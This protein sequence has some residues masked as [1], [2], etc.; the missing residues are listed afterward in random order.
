M[1]AALGRRARRELDM[2]MWATTGMLVDRGHGPAKRTRLVHCPRPRLLLGGSGK[3]HPRPGPQLGTHLTP[4]GS[5]MGGQPRTDDQRAPL[6][7]PRQRPDQRLHPAAQRK[8]SPRAHWRLRY[9]R[10]SRGDTR[11]ADNRTSGRAAG[12][13]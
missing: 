9:R 11:I 10:A 4:S 3:E 12:E 6:H 5:G 13:A 7:T 1:P 8:Y 2:K